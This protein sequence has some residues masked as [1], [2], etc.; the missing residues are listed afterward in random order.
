MENQ[1][2]ITQLIN[3]FLNDTI[4]EIEKEELARLVEQSDRT[5]LSLMLEK[6]WNETDVEQKIFND[7]ESS[8]MLKKILGIQHA[9]P[10]IPFYKKRWVSMVAAACLIL[11]IGGAIFFN[12]QPWRSNKKEDAN[13]T[14]TIIMPGGN[15]ALLT[16]ADGTTIVLDSAANGTLT[17]QGNVDIRKLEDGKLTYHTNDASFSEIL[18]NTVS[19]PRGGQYQLTLADGSKVWLNAA[20]S[21]RFPA[22]FAGSERRVE[23]TGE[24]YFEIA[25]DI[26]K[27]FRVSIAGK[28]E[29]EVLGTYF[30]INAYND[31]PAIKTTLLEGSVKVSAIAD[32]QTLVLKPGQ[33]AILDDQLRKVD[34]VDTDEII[35][36]KTGWFYFDHQ[37]LPAILRQVSRWYNV[38]WR[39]EGPISKKSFSGIVSRENDISD[40]LKIMENAGVRFKIE[41]NTIIVLSNR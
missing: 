7:E 14:A 5:Q 15:K 41:N 16:L 3:Y 4:Q 21:L 17:Q 9:A 40:V 1:Q 33:Q 26:S 19:T 12:S 11:L 22:A 36:W 8:V 20:S 37:E 32:G 30:N 23:I 31:E 25:K 2:R 34:Q 39:Y 27:P 13:A 18:Y 6:A 35:A 24:V 29:V 28:S 38:G 10:V